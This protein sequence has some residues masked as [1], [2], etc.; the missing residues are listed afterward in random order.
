[1]SSTIFRP[2]LDID[3][4]IQVSIRISRFQAVAS[5]PGWR[6][7]S[8]LLVRGS[9]ATLLASASTWGCHAR[10]SGRSLPAMSSDTLHVWRGGLGWWVQ[11]VPLWCQLLCWR[12]YGYG[13]G[14]AIMGCG[15]QSWWGRQ[16]RVE[17]RSWGHSLSLWVGWWHEGWGTTC[18]RGVPRMSKQ[19]PRDLWRGWQ[20]G[21]GDRSG[22]NRSGTC[23]CYWHKGWG[24]SS[25]GGGPWSGKQW[26]MD[27]L[28]WK[29]GQ[30]HLMGGG[31]Y[32]LPRTW[33]WDTWRRWRGCG[34]HCSRCSG[35][36]TLTQGGRCWMSR[37]LEWD[38]WLR[39]RGWGRYWWGQIQL[40][41]LRT[42]A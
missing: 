37:T 24:T 8:S 2:Q 30:R 17:G 38:T 28:S 7:G 1:M 16:A 42:T 23:M 19:G 14:W 11:W 4:G 35:Q 26:F 27:L 39:W 22:G 21:T 32:W 9:S 10:Q 13:Q 18:A 12:C 40:A 5:A 6:P 20:T 15:V 41:Q 33:E 36:G 34:R 3:V 25:T 31:R 29:P